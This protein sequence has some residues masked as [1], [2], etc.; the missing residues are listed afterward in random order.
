MPAKSPIHRHRDTTIGTSESNPTVPVVWQLTQK[1]SATVSAAIFS[2]DR[3]NKNTPKW[4][5]WVP[6]YRQR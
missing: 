3:N 6:R 1:F 5:E 4:Q 2:E